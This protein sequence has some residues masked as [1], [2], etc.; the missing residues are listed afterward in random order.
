MAL[1]LRPGRSKWW[2]GRVKANGRRFAKNLGVEVRGVVPASLSEQGDIV[3]E[4][5]RAKAQAAL[6]KLQLDMKKRSTAEELVQTIHEIR[7]GARVSSISLD[8]IGARWKALP[9]RRSLCDSYLRQA[10]NWITRF[11]DFVKKSN[12]A[13]SEMAQVQSMVC[14]SFLKAEEERG[15]TAKTYNNTL[16]F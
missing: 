16:I 11:V 13:I 3:F 5:S 2:Y 8:E 6:E 10:E 14:R 1:E 12:C 4:R 15:V 7:T 9:R